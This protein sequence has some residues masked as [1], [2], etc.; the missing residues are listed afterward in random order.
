[1]KSVTSLSSL[2][3]FCIAVSV[4]CDDLQGHINA[5]IPL[6]FWYVAVTFFLVTELLSAFSV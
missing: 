1:M 2:G 3:F 4:V 6:N 5:I